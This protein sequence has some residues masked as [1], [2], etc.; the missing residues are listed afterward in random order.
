MYS[1]SQS[2]AV[3][4]GF[5]QNRPAVAQGSEDGYCHRRVVHNN[6]LA[7]ACDTIR[8]RNLLSSDRHVNGFG[9]QPN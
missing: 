2:T 8:H 6:Q 5:R 4:V 1:Q 9:I 3:D 7:S